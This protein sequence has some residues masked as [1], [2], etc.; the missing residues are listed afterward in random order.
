MR[1]NE[2]PFEMKATI[3]VVIIAVVA[4]FGYLFGSV[5]Y[6]IGITVGAVAMAFNPW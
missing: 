1:E 6:M 5:P 4:V 2:L 3:S